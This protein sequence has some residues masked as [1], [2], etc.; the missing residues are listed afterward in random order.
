MRLKD[1]EGNWGVPS[2][3]PFYN[4]SLL[5]GG[6]PVP[7]FA[8]EYFLTESG[9]TVVPP[10]VLGLASGVSIDSIITADLST[11]NA[12]TDYLIYLRLFDE[13]GTPSHTFSG[14]AAFTALK[15]FDLWR[16]EF[17]SESELG[18]AEVSGILAD[19]DSDGLPNLLEFAFGLQPINPDAGEAMVGPVEATGS[20][21]TAREPWGLTTPLPGCVIP[22]NQALHWNRARGR[23]AARFWRSWA[24][25]RTILM[26][27][28]PL[29]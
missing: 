13:A 5:T 3:R 23:R 17:F 8:L 22:W 1:A 12:D 11:L 10:T 29:R 6:T 9:V 16:R 2:L 20:V 26:A 28:K 7:I 4:D 25:R 24:L 19:P 27:R 18:Q 15:A 21:R 14:D